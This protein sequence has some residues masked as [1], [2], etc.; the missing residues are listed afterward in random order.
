VTF[1]PTYFPCRNLA[2]L[3]VNVDELSTRMLYP[4]LRNLVKIIRKR[5]IEGIVTKED[6]NGALIL[7]E[8]PM[9]D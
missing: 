3:G 7:R 6:E 9:A 8:K 2:I 5:D 4:F 1:F